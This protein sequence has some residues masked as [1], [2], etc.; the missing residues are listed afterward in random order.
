[1]MNDTY[2][3]RLVTK[4]VNVVDSLN[5]L[6]VPYSINLVLKLVDMPNIESFYEDIKNGVSLEDVWKKYDL[7]KV[8]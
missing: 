5:M 6:G 4:T 1:M 7:P 2:K 3:Y 8:I